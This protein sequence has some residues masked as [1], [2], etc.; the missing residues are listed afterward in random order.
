MNNY[1]TN[2]MLYC[3]ENNQIFPQ[4]IQITATQ[5]ITFGSYGLTLVKC[6]RRKTYIK[7]INEYRKMTAK[8]INLQLNNME[9]KEDY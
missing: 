5:Y 9:W 3:V 2:Q 1:V 4:D 6:T 8:E 7:H